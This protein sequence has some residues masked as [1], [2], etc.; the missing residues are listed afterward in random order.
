MKWRG[1][2]RVLAVVAMSALFAF[3]VEAP[4]TPG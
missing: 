3:V 1:E 2:T 4:V